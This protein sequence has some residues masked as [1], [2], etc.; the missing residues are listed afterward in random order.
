MATVKLRPPLLFIIP[1][2]HFF[3]TD[4]GM[5]QE[6]HNRKKGKTEGSDYSSNN[7]KDLFFF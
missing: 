2:Y 4:S 5:E 1:F 6:R 3:R 7:Q